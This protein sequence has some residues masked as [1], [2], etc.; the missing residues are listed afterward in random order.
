MKKVIRLTESDLAR[1]VK[2]VLMENETDPLTNMKTC[3]EG[4]GVKTDPTPQCAALL[5]KVVAE[6]PNMEPGKMPDFKKIPELMTD[7]TACAGSVVTFPPNPEVVTNVTAFLAA[8]PTCVM[9][10]AGNSEGEGNLANK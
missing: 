4:K 10:N 9:E 8:L 1:I 2:R 6:I 7:F 3:L 5:M